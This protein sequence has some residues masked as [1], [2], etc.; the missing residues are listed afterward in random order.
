MIDIKK[1]YIID[2]DSPNAFAVGRTPE[3]SAVAVTTGLLYQLRRE[4]L[5]GVIAHEIS[6]II[7]RDTLFLTFAGVM[8]GAIVLIS[9]ILSQRQK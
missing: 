1:T 6:H 8:L 3:K 4:E 9:N 7:N 2:D 5:Q